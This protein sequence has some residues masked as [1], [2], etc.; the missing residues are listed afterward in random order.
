M[1]PRSYPYPDTQ[2]LRMLSISGSKRLWRCDS[3]SMRWEE[4]SV[5]SRWVQCNHKGPGKREA[6]EL[7]LRVRDM[8]QKQVLE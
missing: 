6:R 8:K 1:G 3:G 7:E 4:H 5:I 2:N